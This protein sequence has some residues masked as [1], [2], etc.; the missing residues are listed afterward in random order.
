MS[1]GAFLLSGKKN[2]AI[3]SKR[4]TLGEEKTTNNDNCRFACASVLH[5]ME[6]FS[7]FNIRQWLGVRFRRFVED[8][9][10][11]CNP[12]GVAPSARMHCASASVTRKQERLSVQ[13]PL[14]ESCMARKR[15]VDKPAWPSQLVPRTVR[16]KKE[17]KG[18]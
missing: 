18:L 16:R 7:F 3:A 2:L 8:A 17:R 1:A 4:S 10:L 13:K 5:G 6:G 14:R 15:T 9:P 12:S 11:C